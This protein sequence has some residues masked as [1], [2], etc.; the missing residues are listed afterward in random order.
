MPPVASGRWL[1]GGID[2]MIRVGRDQDVG[3]D[4]DAGARTF[5]ERDDWQ[6]V[7]EVIEDLFSLIR[8]LLLDAVANLRRRR[9]DTAAVANLGE[10]P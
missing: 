2:S 6:S 10:T 5:F 9:E 7:Q 1:Q 8:R 3:A 4:I